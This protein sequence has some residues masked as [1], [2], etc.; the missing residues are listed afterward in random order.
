MA[1]LVVKGFPRDIAHISHGAL[2]MFT[3]M[4]SVNLYLQRKKNGVVRLLFWELAILSLLLIKEIL[5]Q[6]F[7]QSQ[8]I[9]LAYFSA[10]LDLFWLPMIVAFNFR[11][12]APKWTTPFRIGLLFSPFVFLAIINWIFHSKAI[13]NATLLFAIL[14]IAMG[15]YF[16][17]RATVRYD[18]YV[19]DNFSNLGDLKVSWLRKV[20]ILFISWYV[21]WVM[22]T[23][24]DSWYVDAA[25]YLSVII[26]WAIVY[27]YSIHHKIIE[28]I[29]NMLR[30]EPVKPAEE[31]IPESTA[32]EPHMVY[33]M[34]KI[35]VCFELEKLF[36]NPDL[37]IHDVATTVRSNRTYISK[38]INTE[39]GVTFYKFVNR[40]RI[41]HAIGLIN[42]PE[43]KKYTLE[44]IARQSGFNSMTTFYDFFRQEKG[45]TPREYL[46]RINTHP[47]H[48]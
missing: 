37:T 1:F 21:F 3:I 4:L 16:T 27:R 35:C 18:R 9:R 8:D 2:L 43:N 31:S 12:V 39:A 48:E 25:F 28:D 40:Y 33:L 22:S 42:A 23:L 11:V 10:A 30:P 34:N 46:K 47:N 14:F 5:T 19:K 41:L 20:T 26:I 13:F 44:T 29:P 38:A 7:G 15:S 36:L 17:F 45:C 24:L 6:A 32:L